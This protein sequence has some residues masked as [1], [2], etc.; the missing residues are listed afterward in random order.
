MENL[1]DRIV[2]ELTKTFDDIKTVV[3]YGSACEGKS[4]RG[5]SDIN[6]CVV[7]KEINPPDLR[8]AK[9]I[10]KKVKRKDVSFL[11]LTV[12][13]VLTSTDS[14]PLELLDIQ[15]RNRL[16]AG[17]NIFNSLEFKNSDVRLQCEREIKGVRINLY[18][19][20]IRGLRKRN[21]SII[22]KAAVKKIVFSMKGML[23]ISGF[24]V[25]KSPQED[26]IKK[27][28]EVFSF[29]CKIFI[30]VLKSKKISEDFFLDFIEKV[31]QLGIL[32][33]SRRDNA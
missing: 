31:E 1:L 32:I 4:K 9:Q 25:F 28:G 21:I 26:V 16:L 13:H 10:R 24:P 11:F 5:K 15:Q 7:K 12:R 2:T 22:A 6:I 20:Y 3:L 14:Y 19:L 23:Y 30:R 17:E 8:K 18:R 33:D 27:F 29:D